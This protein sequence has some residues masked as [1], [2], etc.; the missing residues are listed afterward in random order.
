[1]EEIM[2]LKIEN[3]LPN[4]SWDS[5]AKPPADALREI[6]GGR[7][8]GKTDINPQWR[9]KVM[10]DTFGPVGHGWTYS[11]DRTWTEPGADGQVMCF[12]Q[13]SVKTKFNGEWGQPVPG[14]GGS[15]LV[16]KERNGLHTS[17]E[18][19]KMALTDALSVALKAHGVASAIYMGLW[20]GAKYKDGAINA[21]SPASVITR[22]KSANA[23]GLEK[24]ATEIKG[25]YHGVDR[26]SI[27]KAY[28]DRVKELAQ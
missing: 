22:I 7:L 23:E 9:L 18:G 13:V 25:I 16:E 28:Q 15:M 1:M 5:L 2:E 19:Y 11:I 24:I 4:W 3:P 8:N 10:H 12:V 6:K 21:P 20:D 17:D 14:M 27:A 26:D